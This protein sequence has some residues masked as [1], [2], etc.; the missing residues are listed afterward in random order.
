VFGRGLTLV[1]FRVQRLVVGRSVL[2]D[3]EIGFEVAA[4]MIEQPALLPQV[5]ISSVST[6]VA[7]MQHASLPLVGCSGQSRFTGQSDFLAI[8][9][10]NWVE[11]SGQQVDRR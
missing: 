9:G 10:D 1:G 5:A 4:D 8:G 7:L 2:A 11:G 6:E 3:V